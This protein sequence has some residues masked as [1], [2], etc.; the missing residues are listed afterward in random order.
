MAFEVRWRG[1]KISGRQDIKIDSQ[2]VSIDRAIGER[3]T[4]KLRLRIP[5]RAALDAGL[6]IWFDGAK[7][8]TDGAKLWVTDPSQQAVHDFDAITI[9][10]PAH[11]YRAEAL[12][13]EPLAYWRLDERA[14]THAEDAAGGADLTYLQGD[15]I[16]HRA[17]QGDAAAV[18]YGGAVEWR[19]TAG[20]G[21]RGSIP[22][23][24]DSF[25]IAGFLRVKAGAAGSRRVL[26]IA[27]IGLTLD[28]SAPP[29]AELTY[30]A[31]G[32]ALTAG[33]LD[34]D[35]WHHVAIVRTP[36]KHELWIDG[37]EATS[38]AGAYGA[39]DLSAAELDLARASGGAAVN[40]ALDEWGIWPAE[41]DVADLAG[42]ARHRRHF[43]GYVYG[44]RDR[45]IIGPQ[46]EHLLDLKL[47]GYGLRLDK[48]F[49]RRT[50]ATASGSSVRA[51]I[52]DVLSEAGV[53]AAFDSHG[54]ELEDT[55]DRAVYPVSSVMDIL[56]D[57]AELHGATVTVDE[58]GTINM[59]RRANIAH[60]G[61]V[62]RG[63]PGA[64]CRS[65]V[66]VSEPRFFASRAVVV[67]RDTEGAYVDEFTM[68]G[69]R[70][71]F[72]LTHQ[73][74]RV[75]YVRLDGVDQAVAG[76]TFTGAAV[77]NPAWTVDRERARVER[78]TGQP[79]VPAGTLTVGYQATP[80]LVAT[81][82]NAA[83]IA[84]IG[85][86]V[87]RKL[88]DDAVDT[89]GVARAKASAY[90]DRHDQLHDRF[91]IE[92]LPGAVQQVPPQVTVEAHFPRHSLNGTRLL[93]ER[94]QTRLARAGGAFHAV[95]HVISCPA[96]DY[97]GDFEDF[98]RDLRRVKPPAPRAI[99]STTQDPDQVVL[100]PGAVAVTAAGLPLSLGGSAAIAI[101]SA[102]WVIPDG[103]NRVRVDG[104]DLAY[105]LALVFMGRC[106]PSGGLGSSQRLEVRL[107][108]ATAGQ[109]IGS[110][111]PITQA[112][113]GGARGTL[114]GLTLPL[115]EFDLT[116]QARVV[117][118]L[119]AGTVWSAGVYL[120][121]G[122]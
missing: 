114:R 11:P 94:V 26:Q 4:A 71:T 115:K 39:V 109:A 36:G 62:L 9:D 23:P 30:T 74:A 63:A 79:T 64:T 52:A 101:T 81:E 47:A 108:D 44:V 57:L 69:T 51:I 86:P 16:E 22:D 50:Y 83:A 31:D 21:A 10:Y 8:W 61:I 102:A 75:D 56:R 104:R 110:A 106:R 46:D 5:P 100:T 93:V 55:V 111:V 87:S 88:E 17:Y 25:T 1:V 41:V 58:W 120:D 60:S 40:L 76:G 53:A 116:F 7:L 103:A 28:L 19:H 24:G 97:A 107:W 33:A 95:E 48:S 122:L 68:D 91:D 35:T 82:D 65:I 27:D 14:A 96:R 12:A 34:A 49:V 118:G 42:R 43:G 112:A 6:D 20:N 77:D 54:V 92:T 99:T 18:P 84:A 121:T 37:V 59:L 38:D 13:L 105:T 119:R 66:R 67:G 117:G 32:Y 78:A 98:W 72:D 29:G 73:P 3:P 15:L 70:R 85:F 89:P 90:L 2:S 113:Q 80:D 45:T